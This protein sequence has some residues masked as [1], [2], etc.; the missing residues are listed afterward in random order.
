MESITNNYPRP[1]CILSKALEEVGY[2]WLLEDSVA[3]CF[4]TT[5]EPLFVNLIRRPGI[6]F[7]LGGPERQRYLTYRPA[8]ACICKPFKGLRNRIPAGRNRF[9]GSLN[10]YKYGL[11]S[12]PR[13]L[14][15]V[16]HPHDLIECGHNCICISIFRPRT[17]KSGTHGGTRI[18]NLRFR[19]PTPYPLGHA[20][21][22]ERWALL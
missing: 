2:K 16:A 18:P 12:G 6:D 8:R 17:G 14:F 3:T 22:Y 15:Q 4:M 11:W 13:I 10:F 21:L 20:G 19:R 9:L 7:Q 1:Y 5:T